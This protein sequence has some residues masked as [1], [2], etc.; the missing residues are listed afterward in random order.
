MGRSVVARH[1]F[2]RMWALGDRKQPIAH[3][4]A[5][6]LLD[7]DVDVE[8]T[9]APFHS[10]STTEIPSKLSLRSRLPLS[11]PDFDRPSP[12]WEVSVG[13]VLPPSLDEADAGEP[14]ETAQLLPVSWQR[15]NHDEALTDPN[16]LPDVVVL[17]DA[18]QLAA[19]PGKLVE[20]SLIHI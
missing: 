9:L 10:S 17:V 11:P 15:L 8:A 2:A 5:L 20:L 19:Q 18:L 16:L 1:R 13:H 4:P 6:V 7:G 14:A 12:S 3:T